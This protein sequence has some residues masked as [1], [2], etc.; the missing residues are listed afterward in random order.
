MKDATNQILPNP[1]RAQCHWM[2]PWLAQLEAQRA[3]FEHA[4]RPKYVVTAADIEAEMAEVARRME[5]L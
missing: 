1:E 5:K 2:P 3:A 4:G